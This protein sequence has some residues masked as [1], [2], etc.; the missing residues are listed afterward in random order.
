MDQGAGRRDGS[1]DGPDRPAACMGWQLVAHTAD[2]GIEADGEDAAGALENAALA[3]TSV[4]TGRDDVHAIR[5]DQEFH[6]ELEAPDRPS[7]LVAFLAELLW[8]LESAGLLWTG[9]G[10]TVRQNDAGEQVVEAQGN[11]VR[12]DPNLHGHGVEVKA[13]TYHDL[14]FERG[15]DGRMHVKVLLD[16]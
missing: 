13:V 11:G 15:K 14:R 8:I 5:A 4:V 16:I 9:G 12:F 7:L 10:V 2:V 3:L 6:F 1:V